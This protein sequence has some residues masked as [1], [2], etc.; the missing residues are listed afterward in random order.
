LVYDTNSSR[1][2]GTAVVV[3]LQMMTQYISVDISADLG[4]KPSRG[5]KTY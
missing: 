4:S 1:N 2:G 3:A 5:A